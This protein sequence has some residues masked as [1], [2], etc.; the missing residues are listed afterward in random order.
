MLVLALV[1]SAGSIR[2]ILAF[3]SRFAISSVQRQTSRPGF[4]TAG[5]SAVRAAPPTRRHLGV[6]A[7]GKGEESVRVGD[8]LSDL[9]TPTMLI[10]LSLAESAIG[11]HTSLDEILREPSVSGDAGTVT[12]ASLDGSVFLHTTVT[13]TSVRDRIN[14]ELGSGKSPVIGRID[15]CSETHVPGGAFLGIGLSNHHVGGYYWA[16]GMGIGASLEAHGVSFRGTEEDPLSETDGPGGGGT[17]TPGGGDGELYWKKRGSDPNSSPSSSVYRG[18][19]TDDSSNSNDGKRSEWAD[20]LVRSDTVQ[21][22]PC[23]AP[24]VFRESAFRRLVGVRRVGRPLGADPIV[25][26]VWERDPSGGGSW[27]PL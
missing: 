1:A 11:N 6:V 21:L 4:L 14:R 16:R 25:E 23:D 18:V 12:I 8:L 7:E 10:E 22:V 5:H 3:T 24:R 19:T 13:D 9:P 2:S 17:G 15:V 27:I 26:R 20:F